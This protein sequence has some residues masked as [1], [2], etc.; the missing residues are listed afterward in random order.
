MKKLYKLQ[1]TRIVGQVADMLE[2]TGNT[3]TSYTE[4]GPNS[5]TVSLSFCKNF[6]VLRYYRSVDI[7]DSLYYG[8]GRVMR[9]I[10]RYSAEL[11]AKHIYNFIAFE[12]NFKGLPGELYVFR[13]TGMIY[14]GVKIGNDSRTF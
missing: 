6:G 10:F 5:Y 12:E 14:F 2:R 1:V 7:T 4:E 13:D 9:P 8:R 11:K 3:V